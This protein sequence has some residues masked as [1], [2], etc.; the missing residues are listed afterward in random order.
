MLLK[1][2]VLAVLLVLTSQGMHSHPDHTRIG[3]ALSAWLAGTTP[4]PAGKA[5]VAVTPDGLIKVI[6]YQRDAATPLRLRRTDRVR[7][8]Y[9]TPRLIEGFINPA[10][11]PALSAN[12]TVGLIELPVDYSLPRPLPRIAA[13]GRP[14]IKL[15]VQLRNKIRLN[16]H[17][18][19]GHTG[20]GVT[21]A[22]VDRGF[23]NLDTMIAAGAV[24]PIPAA[25][26]FNFVDTDSGGFEGPDVIDNLHGTAT[27]EMVSL[28]AP[29]ANL[30]A[31]RCLGYTTQFSKAMEK[32]QELGVDFFLVNLGFAGWPDGDS[33][34]S[35]AM[36]DAAT[37]KVQPIGSSN[38]TAR[39]FTGTFQMQA[40]YYTL[41]GDSGRNYLEIGNAAGRTTNVYLDWEPDKGVDLAL[42]LYRREGGNIIYI[43]QSDQIGSSGHLVC[44]EQVVWNGADRPVIRV[45][46]KTSGAAVKFRILNFDLWSQL[47]LTNSATTITVP[48]DARGAINVGAVRLDAFRPEDREFY[49]GY[50]P[51]ADG[52]ITPDIMGAARI[53]SKT[54]GGEFYGT[55]CATPMVAGVL[56]A[57]RSGFPGMSREALLQSLET[58]AIHAGDPGK[59]N[60]FGYGLLRLP[61]AKKPR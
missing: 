30:V 42:E 56:A 15:L 21:V 31:I 36:A 2:I 11:A 33:P 17:W 26:R 19:F 27:L 43:G 12:N 50:G 55:S 10:E 58:N 7:V 14:D 54:W 9:A 23:R 44:F 34:F 28:F 46:S 8:T 38:N 4:P 22:V 48:S 41:F 45:R 1:P 32:V 52:R 13:D 61:K 24:N 57:Y 16:R 37:A 18:K 40:N 59:N 29:E 49:S 60:S 39:S 6:I 53:W 5:R 51:T 25:R 47:D 35:L 20:A 3:P